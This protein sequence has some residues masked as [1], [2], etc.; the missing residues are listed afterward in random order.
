[1]SDAPSEQTKQCR[2]CGETKPATTEFWYFHRGEPMPPC[3]EC[4]KAAQRVDRTAPK[5]PVTP[6]PGANL[7]VPSAGRALARAG[8]ADAEEV[9]RNGAAIL[10][11]HSARVLMR[12]VKYA[13]DPKSPHHWDAL[14][15]LAER[16]LSLKALTSVVEGAKNAPAVMPT[17]VFNVGAGTPPPEVRPA[18]TV[19]AIPEDPDA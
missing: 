16:G 14:R 12:M 3:K 2:K 5:P 13:E 9:F 6:N 15:F 8:Q 19:E 17:I 1:M 11:R 4:R 18:I 7:P 10:K